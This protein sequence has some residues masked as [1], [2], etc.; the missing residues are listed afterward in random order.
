[1]SANEFDGG[2][3]KYDLKFINAPDSFRKFRQ[4]MW[5]ENVIHKWESKKLST[6]L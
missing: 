1:M 2:D 3:H 5:N 6:A 4:K